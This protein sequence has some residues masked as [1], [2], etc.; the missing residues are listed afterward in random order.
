MSDLLK[1][2]A[3]NMKKIAENSGFVSKVPLMSDH[4][5]FLPVLDILN[6]EINYRIS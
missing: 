2:Y 5:T 3:I 4:D 6:N 1:I